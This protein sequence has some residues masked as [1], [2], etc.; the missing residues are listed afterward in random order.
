MCRAR[1]R[2]RV[3]EL[4]YQLLGLLGP[5]YGEGMFWVELLTGYLFWLN[6]FPFA[7]THM[8]GYT[9]DYLNTIEFKWAQN[10]W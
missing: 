5:S 9:S 7:D 10:V 1:A 6:F 4:G 8:Y 3:G 2:L